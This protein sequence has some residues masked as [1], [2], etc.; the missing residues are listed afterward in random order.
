MASGEG[1]DEVKADEIYVRSTIAFDQKTHVCAHSTVGTTESGL[2]DKLHDGSLA[3][4]F[5][6]AHPWPG[7]ALGIAAAKAGQIDSLIR[8]G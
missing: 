8:H 6:S 3:H 4:P 2:A 1:F 5:P 7:G